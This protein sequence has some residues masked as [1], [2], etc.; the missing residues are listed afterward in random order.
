MTDNSTLKVDRPL[1]TLA[2]PTYNRSTYLRQLLENLE[3]PLRGELRVELIVSDNCSSDDTP[4][5]V[6]EFQARGMRIHSIRNAVNIGAD[7]NFVQC[8]EAA[9]GKYFWI[10]GDDDLLAP[11]AM[12]SILDRIQAEEYDIIYLSQ[13]PIKEPVGELEH[14]QIRN[15]VEIRSAEEFARRIH[16][17]FTFISA[18][19]VNKD[20]IMRSH[21]KPFKDLTGSLLVQLGWTFAALDGFKRG[22]LVYDPLLGARDNI[23][24]GYQLF[25]VFGPRLKAVAEDRISSLKVRRAIF[26]GTLRHYLPLFAVKYRRARIPFREDCTP[27]ERLTPAFRDF[28]SYWVFLYP[29]LTLPL[30]LAIAWYLP[31]HLWDRSTARFMRWRSA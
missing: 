28:L 8:Y 24:G 17:F 26:N 29:V 14:Q 20:T 27:Q 4:A 10:I 6:A 5:L 15:A 31:L 9:R 11:G 12:S 25:D 3:V 21:P 1:L 23:A 19:I 18:N 16:V 30:L 2:I 22:L 13:F 7:G